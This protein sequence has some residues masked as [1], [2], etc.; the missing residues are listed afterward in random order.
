MAQ[1]CTIKNGI[2]VRKSTIPNAGNGLFAQRAFQEGEFI[3]WYDGIVEDISQE[4]RKEL[5]QCEDHEVW[6][7]I[8]G[9]NQ[10]RVVHGLQEPDEGRGGGSFLND[11]FNAFLPANVEIIPLPSENIPP[12]PG[13]HELYVRAKRNIEEGEEFFYNYKSD[14][15]NRFADDFPEI[16]Q[17]HFDKQIRRKAQLRQALKECEEKNGRI[18]PLLDLLQDTPVPYWPELK[19]HHKT[20]SV[21]L[22]RYALYRCDSSDA[23]VLTQRALGLLKE[24]SNAYFTAMG[25]YIC[26]LTEKSNHAEE[27]KGIAKGLASEWNR[28]QRGRSGKKIYPVRVPAN[29]VFLQPEDN[30]TLAHIQVIYWLFERPQNLSIEGDTFMHVLHV[31]HP[32]HPLYEELITQ[33]IFQ[34]FNVQPGDKLDFNDSAVIDSKDSLMAALLNNK[35]WMPTSNDT[36]KEQ[37]RTWGARELRTFLKNKDVVVIDPDP[38]KNSPWKILDDLFEKQG[39]EAETKYNAH[40]LAECRK[41]KCKFAKMAKDSKGSRCKRPI[42]FRAIPGLKY[43]NADCNKHALFMQYVHR[44]GFDYQEVYQQATNETL[45]ASLKMMEKEYLETVEG[46]ALAHNFL[47]MAMARV[48]PDPEKRKVRNSIFRNNRHALRP[49]LL[50]MKNPERFQILRLHGETLRAQYQ[51]LPPLPDDSRTNSDV[52][53]ET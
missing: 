21:E 13:E 32:A 4:R 34:A 33:Y 29:G 1:V 8:R 27:K 19:R 3:T 28:R 24:E 35:L 53:E 16:Y 26:Y 25:D 5:Q 46:K 11:G 51:K 37:W 30:W 6:S 44:A 48:T 18:Q 43:T 49:D 9:V 39:E 47:A 14:H 41:R 12:L 20:W 42:R 36:P 22:C 15:W 23:H 17:K 45:Y 31:L 38:A 10:T 40:F 7:H 52:A 2:D 50:P